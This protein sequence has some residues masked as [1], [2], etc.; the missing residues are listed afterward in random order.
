[1]GEGSEDRHCFALLPLTMGRG[2]MIFL[3][4]L[5]STFKISAMGG[6]PFSLPYIRAQH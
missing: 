2:R 4:L 5:G 1:V 3:E 6:K